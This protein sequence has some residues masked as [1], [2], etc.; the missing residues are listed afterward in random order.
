MPVARA[1][2][3]AMLDTAEMMASR[4][5]G[6]T[7]QDSTGPLCDAATTSPAA[8]VQTIMATAEKTP[9]HGVFRISDWLPV[10][11]LAMIDSFRNGRKLMTPIKS[12]E[13][14]T[15]SMSVIGK[16]SSRHGSGCLSSGLRLAL[17]LS[18]SNYEAE[19][20]R[21]LLVPRYLTYVSFC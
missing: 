2:P 21:Y 14:W 19:K 4:T 7:F 18:P 5:A 3:Q 11:A 8:T 12:F 6:W 13:L 16:M 15:C 20:A 1:E 17:H 10:S 9:I